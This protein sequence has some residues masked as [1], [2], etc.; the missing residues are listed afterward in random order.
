MLMLTI[1][2][3]WTAGLLLILQLVILDNS[4]RGVA[5]QREMQDQV[6]LFQPKLG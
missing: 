2:I 1:Q 4:D 3:F 6:R 5:F